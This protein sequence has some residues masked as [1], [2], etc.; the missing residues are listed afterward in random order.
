MQPRPGYQGAPVA[1]GRPPMPGQGMPP[2]QGFRPPPGMPPMGFRP[3]PGMPPPGFRPG[4]VSFDD[5][6]MIKLDIDANFSLF[7]P[8][9]GFPGAGRGAP[10]PPGMYQRPPPQ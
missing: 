8:P 10:P 4:M 6:R 2:P 3:P 7:Q 5:E 1:Y 9:Q